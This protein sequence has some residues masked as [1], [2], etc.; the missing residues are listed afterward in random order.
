MQNFQFIQDLSH[1]L[2]VIPDDSIVSRTLHQEAG[3][4]VILFGFA[5]GQEL[6]EHSTPMT[7]TLQ[8]LRG[9]ATLT[10]GAET[11]IVGPGAWVQMPPRLPHSIRAHD[12]PVLLLLTMVK[13]A[14]QTEM[15]AASQSKNKQ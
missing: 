5:A 4:R 8:I 9:D 12:E 2:A 13:S 3:L 14:E 15:T 1:S 7:A 6:S 11:F 10:L